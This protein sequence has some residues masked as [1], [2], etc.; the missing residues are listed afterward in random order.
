MGLD[1]VLGVTC[2][3]SPSGKGESCPL[4]FARGFI[5]EACRS[6][7]IIFPFQSEPEV[8]ATFD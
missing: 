3:T 2:D 4:C 6:E 5:C 7:D 8:I 1:H